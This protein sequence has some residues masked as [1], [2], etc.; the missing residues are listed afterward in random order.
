MKPDRTSP[1]YWNRILA[2]EGL[3]MNA[4]TPDSP[5][6][7]ADRARRTRQPRRRRTPTPAHVR[8]ATTPQY[9]TASTT[10]RFGQTRKRN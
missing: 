5:K 8:G 9:Q 10:I 3:A 7:R 4:G 6:N 2:S 1:A